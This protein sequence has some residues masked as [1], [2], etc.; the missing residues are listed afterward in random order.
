M[1][2][3]TFF[4]GV[5]DHI[6]GLGQGR[7]HNTLI[8]ELIDFFWL[9]LIISSQKNAQKFNLRCIQELLTVQNN[10]KKRQEVS[11]EV[12]AKRGGIKDT[13]CNDCWAKNTNRTQCSTVTR[14][15]FWDRGVT[16][17]GG[18]TICPHFVP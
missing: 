8:H 10:G 4:L 9:Y 15:I 5:T 16:I 13:V 2:W 12:Q 7:A 3:W 11:G 6:S 18:R 1:G 14:P 17:L